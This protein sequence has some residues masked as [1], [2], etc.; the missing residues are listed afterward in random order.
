MAPPLERAQLFDDPSLTGIALSRAYCDLMDEWLTALYREAS[1]G[2]DGVA[3]I[4][5]GGYGRGELA[6][7]SDLD[8]VLLHTGLRGIGAIAERIWYPIWDQGLKL[9]HSVRTV[10]EALSLAADDLDTATSLVTIRHLAGDPEL[11]EELAS[12][13]MAL[14]RKRAKRWLGEISKRVA[15]RHEQAGEVAFL[16]EPD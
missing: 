12:K 10:K 5:V 14:W 7:Q 15:I 4:A 13:A 2:A 3:L 11:T 6:P 1:S 16:L 9:G 8:L